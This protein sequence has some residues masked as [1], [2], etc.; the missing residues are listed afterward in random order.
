[1]NRANGAI[2]TG[3]QVADEGGSEHPPGQFPDLPWWLAFRLAGLTSTARFQALLT[4]FGSLEHAWRAG[5]RDLRRV[6]GNR[7]RLLE[8]LAA[9]QRSIDPE[10]ELERL[11][12][13]GVTIQVVA[14]PTYPRLLREV[15]APPPV[16]FVRGAIIEADAV[17]LA[18]VG[19]RK[20]TSY[21]K[22]MATAIAG[23]LAR[24]GVTI[25]SGL[26][27]GIDGHAHRAALDAGG[28]T[29]AVLGSGIHDIYPRHHVDLA[30][31]IAESGAVISDNLP[32]EKPD[33]WNFPARNRII[34]GLSLG[35]LV[36]EAPERSGALITVDFAA[37]QGRDIFAVPGPANGHA[38]AGCNRL[39]RDGARLVRGAGDILGDLRLQGT[40][41]E[42]VVQQPLVMDEDERRVLAVLTGEPMHI[43]DVGE[44]SGLALPR[45]SAILLTLE[46]QEL[47][48][49]AGA[50]HYVRR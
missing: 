20:S 32:D 10:R 9:G 18:I 37:D 41:E 7:E 5:S 16:L 8:S 33:R 43:D 29:I 17:A 48:R 3:V 47:V 44:R 34:S 36:V 45:I 49:N 15:P 42:Q 11:E 50:Q 4:H 28:R 35:V 23:D 13:D 39:L 38:S 24:S 22:E 2:G 12:R 21:G 14:D 31:R 27:T 46:L 19:T 40:P 25:V 30:N 6:I 26:A 1:M